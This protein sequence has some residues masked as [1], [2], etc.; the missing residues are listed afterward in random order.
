M[1]AVSLALEG[2]EPLT[3]DLALSLEYKAD[4]LP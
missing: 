4:A 1:E 3:I 2:T